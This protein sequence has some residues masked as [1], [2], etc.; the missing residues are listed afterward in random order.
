MKTQHAE[1]QKRAA[2]AAGRG[3]GADSRLIEDDFTDEPTHIS[4]G[5]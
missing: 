2:Y 1:H 3:R 5:Q 4:A